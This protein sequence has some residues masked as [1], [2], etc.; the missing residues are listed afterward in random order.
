M[1][2]RQKAFVVPLVRQA[3]LGK[4]S[5]RLLAPHSSAPSHACFPDASHGAAG[6]DAHLGAV[7]R[8]CTFDQS[9]AP[10]S[11]LTALVRISMP[12]GKIAKLWVTTGH[13]FQFSPVLMRQTHMRAESRVADL[14]SLSSLPTPTPGK[15]LGKF[16][17]RLLAMSSPPHLA[18]PPEEDG[19]TPVASPGFPS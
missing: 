17:Q 9:V 5:Q 12:T 18:P 10:L 6:G 2:G 7:K 11:H 3:R 16:S 8:E 15:Y 4:F 14:S 19:P 13:A 1:W